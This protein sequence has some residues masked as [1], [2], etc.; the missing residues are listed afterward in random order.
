VASSDA[1]TKVPTTR[2]LVTTYRN[3][4][5][6]QKRRIA[7]TLYTSATNPVEEPRQ[8]REFIVN[9]RNAGVLFHHRPFWGTIDG[10]EIMLITY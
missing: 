10:D 2:T 9:A 6:R 5:D 4:L 3:L 7:T 1:A 8:Y